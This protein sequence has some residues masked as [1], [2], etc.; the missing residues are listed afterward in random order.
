MQLRQSLLESELSRLRPILLMNPNALAQSNYNKKDDTSIFEPGV[1]ETIID[2][3]TGEPATP[4]GKRKGGQYYR[5][6]EDKVNAG[7]NSPKKKT[8][9][10]GKA[11]L[12]S[13]ARAEHLLLA[14]RRIGRQRASLLSVSVPQNNDGRINPNSPSPSKGK[15]SIDKI[16]SGSLPVTPKTPQKSPTPFKSPALAFPTPGHPYLLQSPSVPHTGNMRPPPYAYVPGPVPGHA[17]FYSPYGYTPM[18]YSIPSPSRGGKAAGVSFAIGPSRIP[19]MPSPSTT[20]TAPG[21]WMAANQPGPSGSSTTKESPLTPFDKLLSAAETVFSPSKDVIT[22]TPIK[23]KGK[24]KADP[25]TTHLV[26]LEDSPTPKKR[27]RIQ[28]SDANEGD[29]SDDLSRKASALDVLA[30]QAM[31]SESNP[32]SSQTRS[33]SESPV[34]S[35]DDDKNRPSVI[36]LNSPKNNSAKGSPSKSTHASRITRSAGGRDKAEAVLDPPISLSRSSSKEKSS[37]SRRSIAP[38]RPSPRTAGESE[39]GK[40]P[41]TRSSTPK[42]QASKQRRPRKSKVAP[43]ID[44][45]K[46]QPESEEEDDENEI[47]QVYLGFQYIKRRLLTVYSHFEA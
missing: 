8:G 30:D 23:G 43:E 40:S 10:L 33:L 39:L 24:G 9:T 5:S 37:S 22:P 1:L 17:Y 16:E 19:T 14:A 42:S 13:D 18:A 44:E 34:D 25:K 15:D 45:E 26:E 47:D 12:S 29:D 41:N 7:S 31:A 46:L 27:R 11:P 35:E 20:P 36:D 38:S 4:K 21:Q 28:S 32:I 2:L 6:K 3:R